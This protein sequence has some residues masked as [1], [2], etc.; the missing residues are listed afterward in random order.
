MPLEVIAQGLLLG[1]SSGIFCLA[2]CAPVFVP[3]MI[4]EDRQLKQNVRVLGELSLGR[5]IAYLLFGLIVGYLG[6]SLEGPAMNK[7]VGLAMV[8]L[9]FM[10]A[11]YFVTRKWPELGICHIVNRKYLNFPLLFGF[12]TGINICPPFLLVSSAAIALGS[13][14]G[15]VLMFGGFFLGTSVYLLLLVPVG[16]A[17]KVKDLQTIGTMTAVLSAALFLLMGIAYLH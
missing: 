4:S 2:T 15:S 13:V 5:L 11:F 16:F 17:G 7:V 8:L 3:Y 1:L 9:S 6:V 12:L 10:M 14:P